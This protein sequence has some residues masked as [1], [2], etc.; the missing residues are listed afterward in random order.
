MFEFNCP[1]CKQMIRAGDDLAGKRIVCPHCTQSAAVPTNADPN[2]QGI[3]TPEVVD[4]LPVL[5][6][7][8]VDAEVAWDVPPSVRK[9]RWVWLTPGK[10]VGTIAITLVITI[11][12]A[13]L[14]VPAQR[15]PRSSARIQSVNNLKN[16]AFAFHD[17]HDRH[18]RLPFNGSDIA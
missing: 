3:T 15:F 16:I 17:F 5:P 18:K 9:R 7:A 1:S 10:I 4:A 2:P 12:I 14:L 8:P 13:L 11:G 6:R